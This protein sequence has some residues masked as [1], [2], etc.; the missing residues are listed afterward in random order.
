MTSVTFL[1]QM[2]KDPCNLH[3]TCFMTPVTLLIQTSNDPCDLVFQF[4]LQWLLMHCDPS[5]VEREQCDEIPRTD[6]IEPTV[7]IKLL[8]FMNMC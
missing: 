6:V 4:D 5:Y 7:S 1:S 3:I 8:F 2:S